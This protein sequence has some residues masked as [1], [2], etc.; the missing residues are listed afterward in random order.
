M[1]TTILC[2]LENAYVTMSNIFKIH[3]CA[4]MYALDPPQ[5]HFLSGVYAKNLIN[6]NLSNVYCYLIVFGF[7][8]G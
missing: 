3:I 4:T 1:H 2:Q 8:K 6:V 5:F 7:F